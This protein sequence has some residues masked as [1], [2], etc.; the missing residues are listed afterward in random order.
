MDKQESLKKLNNLLESVMLE[1]ASDLHIGV[2]IYPTLRVDGKL[3][4]L[5]SKNILTADDVKGMINAILNDK[6]LENYKTKGDVDLSI[7][8]K[9]NVRFRVGVYKQQGNDAMAMRLIPSNIRTIDELEIPPIVKEFS[10]YSQGFCLIVGPTGHG[11]STTMAALIDEINHSRPDHIITI[12]DPIE[13]IFIQDK[14]II[15]QREIGQDAESFSVAL[16]AAFREDADVLMVGEM[17]DIETIRTAVTAAE[18]GH[19]VF[20]TLHTN[21]AAQTIH[22]IVDMFPAH[23]QNQIR[24]QLASSL[25]GII[26]QRL[27]PKIDGGRV[28]AV[29]VMFANSAVKNLIRESKIHQLDL[30]IETGGNEGMITLNKSL[31]GLVMHRVISME[32]AKLYSTDVGSLKTLAGE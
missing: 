31:A 9:N 16:R 20:A 24:A 12:E 21:D 23:Q 10:R 3:I 29:E 1:N 32:N 2:G 11:K 8:I 18:T 22:R 27:V 30:V 5:I 28:P 4:P 7:S 13:Y 26:S 19:L 15:D 25:V 14:C 17:R 6:Q